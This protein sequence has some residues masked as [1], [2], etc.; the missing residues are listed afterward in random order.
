M[1]ESIGCSRAH[2]T[3]QGGGGGEYVLPERQLV[4]FLS[5]FPACSQDRPFSLA[6][7]GPWLLV[8]PL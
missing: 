1:G 2:R 8:V 5:S 3:V 4:C 6:S 7:Q